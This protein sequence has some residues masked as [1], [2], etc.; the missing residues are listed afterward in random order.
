MAP[1][2]ISVLR[3]NTTTRLFLRPQQTTLA[4]SLPSRLTSLRVELPPGI[5]VILLSVAG[6]SSFSSHNSH[7]VLPFAS[8]PNIGNT[9]LSWGTF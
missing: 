6:S 7:P 9:H 2:R 1:L 5:K 3:S 8:S 4:S